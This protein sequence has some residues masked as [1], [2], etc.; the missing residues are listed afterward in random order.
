MEFF[1]KKTSFDF[2]ACRHWATAF[3]II[4]M[5]VSIVSL[6]VRGINWGLDFTGGTLIE[7]QY[8]KAPSLTQLRKELHTHNFKDAVVQNYGNA[9]DVIIRVAPRKN[10]KEDQVSKSVVAILKRVDS[11][12][13]IMRTDQVGAQVGDELMQ[14]GVLAVLTALLLTAFYIGIRFEYRFAI[15]AAVAL[16]HDPILILGIFSMTGIEFDLQTLAAILAVIGYSLNDTIVVFDRVKEN[17]IKVR[18]KTPIE[19]MNLSLN[20]TLSRTI[21]TSMLTLIVVV[22]LLLF[23]GPSIFGFALALAIGI[24]IGTYSSIYIAGSL[25]ITLG[26][27]KQDLM[28]AKKG[29]GIVV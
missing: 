21:M 3:S 25:S 22:A 19:I 29:S 9:K 14:K 12:I 10:I 23:G 28:P 15:G 5:L 1:R 11:N 2:L 24:I 18:N 17:F 26:L 4:I 8:E 27:S 16:A 7:V 13:T 20:Q 6:C